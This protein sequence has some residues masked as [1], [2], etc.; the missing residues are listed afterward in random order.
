MSAPAYPTTGGAWCSRD[1]EESVVSA[2][3]QGG[4][5]TIAA[6][7]AVVRPEAFVGIDTQTI[8]AAMLTLVERGGSTDPVSVA[9]ELRRID[10]KDENCA[11][12][13]IGVLLDTVPTTAHVA[14]HAEI[15][16][17]YARRR[18]LRDE[19]RAVGNLLEEGKTDSA[20]IASRLAAKLAPAIVSRRRSGYVP[21]GDTLGDLLH[22]MEER[23]NTARV[24]IPSG[25]PEIDERIGGL[26]PG[27]L[28]IIAGVSG[29]GKT[30]LALNIARYAAHEHGVEVGF[31][32]AEMTTRQLQTRL[33]NAMARV[34]T[35]RTRTGKMQP[36]EWSRVMRACEAIRDTT[37]I[38]CDDTPVP[39]IGDVLAR[40]RALKASHPAVGLV[41]VDYIQL[42]RTDGDDDQRALALDRIANGL[43]ALAKEL[44][45]AVI[46]T[47]QVD[48][49]RVE[50]R[51][52][53]RPKV[54]DLAWSQAIRYAADLVLCTY[55]PW[56]YDQSEPD[57]IMEVTV[58]KARELAPFMA[59]LEF[60]GHHMLVTS[61]KRRAAEGA[62]RR[63]A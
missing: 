21:V 28:A 24:G 49:Q 51:D 18:A 56:M 63:A 46:A 36:D 1:A 37:P 35:L 6:A 55:R 40:C 53:K 11:R 26:F 17:E 62:I 31:Q 32:S 41:V 38:H 58:E 29:G 61:A 19:V 52:D 42:L 15:V 34:D 39:S 7:R 8:F 43:K 54:S 9:E 48:A 45:V 12:D 13:A 25:F 33:L 16:A 23:G 4:P 20:T 2:C 5:E 60:H 30:A 22:E 44:D 50:R 10:P 27:D 14:H 57:T 3:L 59:R 47:A